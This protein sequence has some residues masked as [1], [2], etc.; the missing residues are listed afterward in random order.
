ML[1]VL[2]SPLQLLRSLGESVDA[3]AR[4]PAS[5]ERTLQETNGLIVDARAQLT[6]LGSQI[7]RMMEQLDKM[8]TVT[9]RLVDGARS[10]S[11]IAGDAQR[12]MAA[13][14]EQLAATNRTLEQLVRFAEPLDR[15][16]KRV[17]ERFS[18]VTGRAGATDDT[19]EM[20]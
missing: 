11:T 12:Q 18:R 6:L 10:V 19:D 14:T 1:E 8:A 9:D 4:L 16:G 20:P 17:A 15:L 2:E 13:T 5:I 3:L 7:G